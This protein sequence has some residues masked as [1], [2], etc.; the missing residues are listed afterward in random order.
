M[1]I[2]KRKNEMKWKSERKL[3]VQVCQTSKL[4]LLICLLNRCQVTQANFCCNIFANL[5]WTYHHVVWG[6]TQTDVKFKVSQISKCS[7]W[8]PLW[9]NT[10]FSNLCW[11]HICGLCTI[12]NLSSGWCCNAV[13]DKIT[14]A[15][16][17]LPLWISTSFTKSQLCH[18]TPAKLSY[19]DR[20]KVISTTIL[21]QI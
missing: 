15:L 8:R 3:Y 12:E 2:N 9:K 18:P 13:E 7:E 17:K 21:N 1:K 10:I 16:D 19:L 4:A 11:K 20:E 6:P 14:T 5:N